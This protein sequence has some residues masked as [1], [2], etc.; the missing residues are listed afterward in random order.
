MLR[1]IDGA[2]SLD[3]YN[4]SVSIRSLEIALAWWV[5]GFPLAILYFVALFRI[6][7]GKAVAAGGHEGY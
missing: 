2:R 7:R 5:V 1:A 4:S 3:A 6:H